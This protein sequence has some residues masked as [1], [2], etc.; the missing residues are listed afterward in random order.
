MEA[1]PRERLRLGHGLA[2]VA[3]L[4]RSDCILIALGNLQ[5]RRRSVADGDSPNN[6]R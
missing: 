1:L 6:L 2:P 4:Y 5:G 3:F